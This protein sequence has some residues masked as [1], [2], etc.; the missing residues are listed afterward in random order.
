MLAVIRPVDATRGHRLCSVAERICALEGGNL[1]R[2]AS[3][4]VDIRDVLSFSLEFALGA[5]GLPGLDWPLH[6]DVRKC[7][8]SFH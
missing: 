4:N 7:S 1:Q 8:Y 5:F 3:G 6:R 2:Q